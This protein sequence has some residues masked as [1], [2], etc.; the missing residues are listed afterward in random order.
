[1]DWNENVL[2]KNALD[3]KALDKKALD[4]NRAHVKT[5]T[6]TYFFCIDTKA[7]TDGPPTKLNKISIT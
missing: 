7:I 2:D 6:A 5:I 1:M 3:E 4:E